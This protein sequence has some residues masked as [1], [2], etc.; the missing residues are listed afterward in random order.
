VVTVRVRADGDVKLFSLQAR[1]CRT[2]VPVQDDV[3]FSP[4][5]GRCPLDAL[6]PSADAVAARAL[7][8]AREATLP[9]RVGVG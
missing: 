5:G 3:S 2:G 7:D 9:F 1:L 6:S 8:G 4:D